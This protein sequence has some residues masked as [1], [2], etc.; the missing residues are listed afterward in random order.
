MR[1]FLRVHGRI[2]VTTDNQFFTLLVVLNVGG[3][4]FYKIHGQKIVF[5]SLLVLSYDCSSDPE[6]M[7]S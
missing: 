2:Y 3:S 1:E 5:L 4:A 6:T 7:P